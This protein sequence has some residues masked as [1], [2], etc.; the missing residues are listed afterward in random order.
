MK[1]KFTSESAKPNVISRRS[2]NGFFEKYFKGKGIDI[3]TSSSIPENVWWRQLNLDCV[4]YEKGTGPHADSVPESMRGDATY[5]AEIG[6]ETYDWVY[7]SHCLEHIKDHELALKNW[8]RILKP[9]GYLIVYIP[10]VDYYERKKRKPSINNPD[11]KHFYHPFYE[12]GDI[13]S[14][15]N[16][17][18]RMCGQN[19]I[20]LINECSTAC[21]PWFIPLHQKEYRH[22]EY[23]IEVVVRKPDGTDTRL[24]IPKCT[25]KESCFTEF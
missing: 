17:F 6:D 18:S 3:G 23:S 21:T 11:H 7:S 10:H 14:V 15:F 16:L 12:N 4:A 25:K 2:R 20:I 13:E 22:G 9:G 19:N 24:P 8:M 1:V 5:M